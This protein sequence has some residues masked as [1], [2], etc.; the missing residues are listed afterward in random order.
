MATITTG[1][2]VTFLTSHLG[3]PAEVTGTVTRADGKRVNVTTDAGRH[4]R[5][6]K[7]SILTVH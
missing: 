1:T 2:K 5:V 7:T 6:M 3:V 4:Y